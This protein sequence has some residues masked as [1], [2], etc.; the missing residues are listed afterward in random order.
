MVS[1]QYP[2]A[3]AIIALTKRELDLFFPFG[4]RQKL[5][6]ALPQALWVD[7]ENLS[8]GWR[9]LLQEKQPSLIVSGWQTPPIPEELSCLRYVCHVAGSVRHLVSAKMVE[10]GVLVTNWGDS[11][12]EVVAEATLAMILAVLR[13]SQYFGNLMHTQRGWAESPSGSMSLF[14]RRVGIFGFGAIARQLVPLL[15]PFRTEIRAL[16]KGVPSEHFAA[17]GVARELELDALFAWADV[18]VVAEASTPETKGVVDA[19]LLARMRPGAA[20]VNV[21]RGALVQE[22]A[23]IDAVRCRRL[24]VAL[25]VFET[26]PL[27]PTSPLRGLEDAVLMPHVAGVTVDRI[28]FC[29]ELALNNLL[30]FQRGEAVSNQITLEIYQRST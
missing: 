7:P 8:L 29:G 19:A 30:R 6:L 15:R 16:S 26:E 13:R 20:L 5:A 1:P 14:D 10:R 18:V 27:P 4:S 9:E 25:D 28:P 11:M 2:N 3:C 12:A 22:T 17:L 24:R 21:A 23:L